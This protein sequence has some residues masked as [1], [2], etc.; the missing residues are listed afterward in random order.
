MQI[1]RNCLMKPIQDEVLT[2]YKRTHAGETVLLEQEEVDGYDSASEVPR[3]PFASKT[4]NVARRDVGLTSEMWNVSLELEAFAER[5]YQIKELVEKCPYLTGAQSVHLM[6]SLRAANKPSLCLPI[7]LFPTGVKVEDR[8]R[9]AATI[10]ADSIHPMVIAARKSL[11]AELTSRFLTDLPSETRLVQLYMSKQAD[12]TKCFPPDWVTAAKS[13]YL[14]W[15]RKAASAFGV[16]T[17]VSPPRP[18]KKQRVAC[19]FDR[20]EEDVQQA[21]PNPEDVGAG[22]NAI[23]LEIQRWIQSNKCRLKPD[24]KLVLKRYLAKYRKPTPGEDV[25]DV[26][27]AESDEGGEEDADEEGARPPEEAA[28]PHIVLDN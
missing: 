21:D 18:K 5:P 16:G 17:R 4:N 1:T 2:A 28:S 25:E 20:L 9:K 22:S 19:L 7:K 6:I 23:E 26:A 13:F 14:V 12:M 27:E 11:C 10:A 15:L 24:P 3:T 8:S